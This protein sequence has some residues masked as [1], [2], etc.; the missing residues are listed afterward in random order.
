M[1]NALCPHPYCPISKG[2][3]AFESCD[4][5]GVHIL[6]YL[7]PELFDVLVRAV[8]LELAQHALADAGNAEYVFIARRIQIDRHEDILF[9]ARHFGGIHIL[10]DITRR[11]RS[12]RRGS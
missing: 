3:V 7:P 10:S 9:H 11:T 8:L 2:D 12:K 1:L 4:L 5:F 6:A